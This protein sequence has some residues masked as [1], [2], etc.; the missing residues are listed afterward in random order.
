MCENGVLFPNILAVLSLATELLSN[1][2]T[3]AALTEFMGENIRF[4]VK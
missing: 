2:S 4:S 1:G 3:N